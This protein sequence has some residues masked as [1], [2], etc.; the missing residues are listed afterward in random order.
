M[1]RKFLSS[2]FAGEP[3]KEA[4]PA[5]ITR[6]W[7]RDGLDQALLA[8]QAVLYKYSPICS[9]STWIGREVDRFASDHPDTPVYA[10]DV[11]GQR[12]LSNWIAEKFGV[13][14]ESPQAFVVRAGQA[15]WNASHS[16]ITADALSQQVLQAD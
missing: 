11:I 5:P 2:F 13:R 4:A 15:T 1:L 9:V 3:S 10:I 6:L 12:E 8:P 16:A 14:H 7:D